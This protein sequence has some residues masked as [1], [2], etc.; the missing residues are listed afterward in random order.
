MNVSNRAGGARLR[1]GCIPTVSV[2]LLGGWCC[3]HGRSY[4]WRHRRAQTVSRSGDRI[5]S[6]DRLCGERGRC[7][8]GRAAMKAE[9][10]ARMRAHSPW[11]ALPSRCSVG[12]G[13]FRSVPAGSGRNAG[14][15]CR[16]LANEGIPIDAASGRALLL[17]RPRAT[18]PWRGVAGSIAACA[19]ACTDAFAL[20]FY[21]RM[22]GFCCSTSA[23]W[24]APTEVPRTH[25]AVE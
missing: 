16:Q 12:F 8:V 22:P 18:G 25:P 3:S 2:Q 23:R 4:P 13:R 14:G 17:L 9:P 1:C 15:V 11:G 7:G 24:G 6:G 20:S 5:R 10:P 19:V 21:A